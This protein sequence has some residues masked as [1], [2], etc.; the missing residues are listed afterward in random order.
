MAEL[1]QVKDCH[2]V[3]SIS[4]LSFL[5]NRTSLIKLSELKNRHRPLTRLHPSRASTLAQS[6]MYVCV[7]VCVVVRG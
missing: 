4:K 3:S 6:S 5:M 2:Q 1:D 7:C